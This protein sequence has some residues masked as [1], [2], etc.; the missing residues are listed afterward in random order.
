MD[1]ETLNT[2]HRIQHRFKTAGHK[3]LAALAG[4]IEEWERK[5]SRLYTRSTS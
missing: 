5:V 4:V 1:Q 3:E 2:I